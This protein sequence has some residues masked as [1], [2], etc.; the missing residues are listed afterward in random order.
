MIGEKQPA[1]SPRGEPNVNERSEV[2]F[3]ESR[4]PV[5]ATIVAVILMLA[6]L[7]GRVR[8]FP[9]WT[10]YLLGVF[11]LTPIMTV[12]LTRGNARWV[13]IE[14]AATLLFVA[15]SGLGTL[16]NLLNLIREIL[17]SS[18]QVTGL[19]LLASSIAVW[20]TNVLMFALLYW[21]MDR[22]GP[23][24]RGTGA[25]ILPDLLFPQQSAPSEDVPRN[26]KPTFV[27]FLYLAYSTATAFSTTDVVPV[28]SRAKMLMMFE[29]AIS[30]ATIVV[31]A[32]RAINVL[33]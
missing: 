25:G 23:Q 10:P 17:F 28:T 13:Q 7:P 8:I 33:G 2:P 31:V 21:Q 24:A 22:G 30:L 1:T 20:V 5:V 3:F 29:S 19:R 4:W 18:G 15:L 16:I 6:A 14:R 26:W 9:S 32:A 12:G 27:D 11:V